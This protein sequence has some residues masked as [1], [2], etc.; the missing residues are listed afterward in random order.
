MPFIKGAHNEIVI[1]GRGGTSYVD[2]LNYAATRS[3]DGLIILTDGYGPQPEG[4]YKNQKDD[5]GIHVKALTEF[6]PQRYFTTKMKMAWICSDPKAFYTNSTW[7]R[8]YGEVCLLGGL[9]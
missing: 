6:E 7:M 8:E 1:K 3:Y 2:I 4:F 5:V 9:V